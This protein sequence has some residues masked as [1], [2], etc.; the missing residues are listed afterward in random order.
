[1]LSWLSPNWDMLFYP[2]WI[3]WK[4][5]IVESSATKVIGFPDLGSCC[6]DQDDEKWMTRFI[7]YGAFRIE[8]HLTALI[9]F[10][11]FFPFFFFSFFF[12]LFLLIYLSDPPLSARY[13]ADI[14]TD[15]P[16]V[17][18]YFVADWVCMALEMSS[19]SVSSPETKLLDRK[20]EHAG[21][22]IPTYL[23]TWASSW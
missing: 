21:R 17:I 2:Q 6:L 11:F 19:D 8:I 15:V 9:L 20:G 12:F 10:S 22:G 18:L 13:S 4:E 5:M 14:K 7:W 23:L 3:W 1:M 16:V